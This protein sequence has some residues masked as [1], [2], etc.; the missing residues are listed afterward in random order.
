MPGSEGSYDFDSVADL[1]NQTAASLF[2]QNAITNDKF[3]GAAEWG[4]AVNSFYLQDEWQAT[5]QLTLTAGLRYDTYSSSGTI[6]E[7]PELHGSVRLLK[8]SRSGWAQHPA[9]KIFSQF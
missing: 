8:Y 4:F 6:T 2:Y 1:Q 9:A 3:D 7:K 5:D